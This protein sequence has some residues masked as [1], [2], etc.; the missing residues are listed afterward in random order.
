MKLMETFVDQVPDTSSG[1]GCYEKLGN[2]NHWIESSDD[3]DAMYAA[4]PHDNITLW[5]DGRDANANTGGAAKSQT[6]CTNSVDEDSPV[7]KRAKKE[8][9]I[10]EVFKI[11]QENQGDK[12]STPQLSLWARMYGN[13]DL[14]K[15][16]NVPTI[17][18]QPIKKKKEAKYEPLTEA[19]A[20]AA[21]AI[22]KK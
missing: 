12:Y 21:T 22:T 10:E 13:V 19:L 15:P 11:L 9:N 3:L 18:G 1:F 20:G 17:T 2:A 8:Q 16:P 4:N 7:R 5:C 6:K 14:D